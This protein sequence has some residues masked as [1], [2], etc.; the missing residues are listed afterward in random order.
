MNDSSPV[1]TLHE[2]AEGFRANRIPITEDILCA[3]IEAGKFPFA[4]G[5]VGKQRKPLIF[6]NAFYGWLS[7]MMR[8]EVVRT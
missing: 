1:M 6:R 8:E 3:G 4:V 2:C 7:D 5:L